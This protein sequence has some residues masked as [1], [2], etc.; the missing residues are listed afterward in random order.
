MKTIYF[1]RHGETQ[2]NVD[3]TLA[4]AKTDTPL[5]ELGISQ[6]HQAA[7]KMRGLGIELIV[8]SPLSRAFVT[9]EIIAADI[10]Y[11]KELVS[12]KL[13]IERDFGSATGMAYAAAG[14]AIDSGRVLG[15]ESLEDF[16]ERARSAIE[17][18]NQQAEATFLVVSH[19][20]FG[21]MFATVAENLNPS[22][23]L[24]YRHLD[25]ADYY[26]IELS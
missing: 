7:Q 20:G 8:S 19:G 12:S 14:A 18:L 26:R 1:V 25:N 5:T 24:S 13:F 21:Q 17:W 9:A 10:G 15:L 2:S 22:D 16:T 23:F 6:A 3:K 4:G 11:S